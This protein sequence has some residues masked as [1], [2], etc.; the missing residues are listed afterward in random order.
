MYSLV[1]QWQWVDFPGEWEWETDSLTP[2]F[3]KEENNKNF[4]C[5][6]LPIRLSFY[7]SIVVWEKIVRV[8]HFILWRKGSKVLEFV[9]AVVANLVWLYYN[10]LMHVEMYTFNVLLVMSSMLNCWCA[11]IPSVSLSTLR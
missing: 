2:A 3:T 10:C 4:C 9:I 1:N 8:I 5:S 7:S 11:Y 6:C